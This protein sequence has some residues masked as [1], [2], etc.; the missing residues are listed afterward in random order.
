MLSQH[1]WANNVGICCLRLYVAKSFFFFQTLRNNSYQH[2]TACANGHVRFNNFEP[3]YTGLYCRRETFL[4]SC[5]FY[6]MF[7]QEFL[8]YMI[9][10]FEMLHLVVF[11]QCLAVL[12]SYS[13][14]MCRVPQCLFIYQCQD[15]LQVS[16]Y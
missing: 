8:L 13:S 4:F 6:Y 3:A 12:S 10:L 11:W 2:S 5:S 9:N 14:M 7:F 15:F 1:C 16:L